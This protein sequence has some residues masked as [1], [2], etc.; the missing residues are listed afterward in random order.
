[1]KYSERISRDAL[2]IAADATDILTPDILHKARLQVCSRADDAEEATKLMMMLG[3]HP[4]QEGDAY[5]VR[6]PLPTLPSRTFVDDRV[7]H[8]PPRISNSRGGKILFSPKGDAK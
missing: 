8:T 5:E 2:M 4:S 3:I 7:P 1:M 6:G